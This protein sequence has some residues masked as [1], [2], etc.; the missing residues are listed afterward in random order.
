MFAKA[1]DKAIDEGKGWKSDADKQKYIEM[2]EDDDHLP[3]IFCTNEEELR[4]APDAE[5]FAELFIENETPSTMMQS[6]KAKGNESI[7]LGRQNQAKNV[8]YYRDAI[9]HYLQSIAWG[10]KIMPTD[11]DPP[12]GYV[13][14]EKEKLAETKNE[15]HKDFTRKELNIYKSTLLAN[16]AMA[17]MELKNWGYVIEDSLKSL[18]LDG[19][20]VKSWYRLAKAHET[21]REYEECMAACE[22]GLKVEED[23]KS[24]KKIADKVVKKAEAARIARQKK[25]RERVRRVGEVKSL[26]KF[27]KDK[28]IKLGRVPLV[29]TLDDDGDEDD[30]DEKRWNHQLPH[31]GK[32]PK[33]RSLVEYEFPAM[34]LY[35]A[36]GQSDFVEGVEAGE[37]IA[38]RLAQM[39]PD[40]DGPT[41]MPWDY[42]DEYKCSNLAIYF[43]IHQ[44]PGGGKAQ[45][46]EGV[47]RLEDMGECMRFFGNARAMKGS[48]GQGEMEKAKK[49]EREKMALYVKEWSE[50]HGR[51]K[52]PDACDVMR[53]HPAVTLEQVLVDKRMVVP[54]F[55]VTFL[56]FPE[57]HDAHKAFMRE[58]NVVGI[59]QP[60]GM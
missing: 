11:E 50:E 49:D 41:P 44:A 20:N 47:R 54:N 38:L 39:F 37:M 1:M 28:G 60:E 58:R 55:I 29:S 23:N 53:V 30:T 17:H 7:R 32:M 52:I 51:H 15:E 42:N 45:H 22:K 14:D 10:E 21:R 8:Q 3:A 12:E 40:E 35:P 46:W 16:K 24:L 33:V 6:F 19:S 36:V 59:V 43:E 25:E 57:E 13:K 48:D 34:F 18:M 26:W 9:N 31:T 56:V 2:L 27:C 5:A 4:N